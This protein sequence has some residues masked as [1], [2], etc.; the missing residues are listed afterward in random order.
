MRLTG[1]SGRS[2]ASALTSKGLLESAII[3]LGPVLCQST[4]WWSWGGR[5]FG[6]GGPRSSW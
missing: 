3:L 5:E 2:Q 6:L 1:L 4:L